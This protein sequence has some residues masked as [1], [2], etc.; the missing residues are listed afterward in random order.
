MTAYDINGSRVMVPQRVDPERQASEVAPN[1]RGPKGTTGYATR[2]ASV[3]VEAIDTSPEEYRDDLRRL[4]DGAIALEQQGIA[5]LSTYQRQGND[6]PVAVSRRRERGPGYDLQQPLPIRVADGVRASRPKEHHSR[7]GGD[8]RSNWEREPRGCACRRHGPVRRCSPRPP[9][10]TAYL[11][12][13]GA[14]R[15]TT[16]GRAEPGL[17]AARTRRGRTMWSAVRVLVTMM[18]V[19]LATSVARIAGT[20]ALRLEAAVAHPRMRSPTTSPQPAC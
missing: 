16:K 20:W 3:F 12:A 17:D 8:R 9:R 19:T 10:I 7:R 4:S 13:R 14:W 1:I 18:S 11:R 15:R 6:Q 2:G 5:R